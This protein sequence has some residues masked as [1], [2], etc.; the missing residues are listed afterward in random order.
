[1][2]GGGNEGKGHAGIPVPRRV[3]TARRRLVLANVFVDTGGLLCMKLVTSVQMWVG[4]L[5]LRL[6]WTPVRML[7]LLG[8]KLSGMGILRTEKALKRL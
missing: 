8:K 4:L 3:D 2:W 7:N 5:L 6:N 1:M